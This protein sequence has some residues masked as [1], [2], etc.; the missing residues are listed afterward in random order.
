M[1]WLQLAFISGQRLRSNDGADCNLALS[2]FRVNVG[3]PIEAELDAYTPA[4]AEGLVLGLAE[5]GLVGDDGLVL[6][7]LVLELVLL[8]LPWDVDDWLP[9][10]P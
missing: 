8:E 9:W 2:T 6:D 3:C 1:R 5:L 7:G 10:P 4:L